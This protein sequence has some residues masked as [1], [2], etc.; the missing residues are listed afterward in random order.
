MKAGG[1]Y[2]VLELDLDPDV[3]ARVEALH[4]KQ[5]EGPRVLFDSSSVLNFRSRK[6]HA[7]RQA[8]TT[9]SLSVP[10]PG[11]GSKGVCAGLLP[12]GVAVYTGEAVAFHG[13]STGEEYFAVVRGPLGGASED[14]ED[15]GYVW[16]SWL[17]PSS[18]SLDVSSLRSISPDHFTVGPL[19]PVPQCL[20]A[21]S[22]KLGFSYQL[23]PGQDLFWEAAQRTQGGPGAVP[24]PLK[25]A[26][27]AA[28]RV[29][30]TGLALWARRE[31]DTEV[32]LGRA[33]PPWPWHDPAPRGIKKR[34]RRSF[35]KS[36]LKRSKFLDA[37]GSIII[38][39]QQEDD[40]LDDTSVDPL[41]NLSSSVSFTKARDEIMNVERTVAPAWL[42]NTLLPRPNQIRPQ[43]EVVDVNAAFLLSQVSTDPK[44]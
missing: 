4:A 27:D 12:S 26:D 34:K 41:D 11:E 30:G 5:E 17:V 1:A 22:R 19:E 32:T 13:P 10:R 29:A 3:R 35:F 39:A 6:A 14:G 24:P 36:L 23:S 15:D 40:Y 2:T 7:K 33:A 31:H 18:P 25:A 43:L 16:V 9:A 21:V 44:L 42:N 28:L 38:S 20:G 37:S 8:S